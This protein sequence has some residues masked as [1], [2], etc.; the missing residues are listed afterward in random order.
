MVT[1]LT[2]L[3]VDM[4]LYLCDLVISS[5]MSIF[6]VFSTSGIM[7]GCASDISAFIFPNF[8]FLGA[9][10]ELLLG[11]NFLSSFLLGAPVR[12]PLGMPP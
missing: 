4:V 9:T 11:C 12:V 7:W 8:S 10:A 6:G 5:M 3:V 2:L 1:W